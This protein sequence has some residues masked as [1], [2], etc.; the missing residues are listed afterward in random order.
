MDNK[1]KFTLIIV[2]AIIIIAGMFFA[3]MLKSQNDKRKKIDM[4]I[5][6]T[7]NEI[8]CKCAYRDCYDKDI[9]MIIK[10]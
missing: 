8:E 9:V 10:K 1:V 3:W 4:C 2:I 5:Q 7:E 6:K